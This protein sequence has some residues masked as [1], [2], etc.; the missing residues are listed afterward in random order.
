MYI[1]SS[2]TRCYR[3]CVRLSL[4]VVI[5][6]F[7]NSYLG[8]GRFH[9]ESAMIHNPQVP[10]F[11]YDPYSRKLTREYYNYDVMK[12]NRLSSFFFNLII[13]RV[14]EAVS[15]AK[16]CKYFGIIHGTLGRQGN[17]KIVEVC[18]FKILNWT[19]IICSVQYL[20]TWASC[21]S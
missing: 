11:Q 9:L 14:V 19:E 17:I 15:I 4:N 20:W 3:T 6:L 16:T 18:V 1:A 10:A 12:T 5:I 8:D 13:L 2:S 21:R 7:L